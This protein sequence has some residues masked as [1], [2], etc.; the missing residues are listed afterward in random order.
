MLEKHEYVLVENEDECENLLSGEDK[1]GL[2]E[3]KH[4]M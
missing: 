1:V 4:S 2:R 3:S